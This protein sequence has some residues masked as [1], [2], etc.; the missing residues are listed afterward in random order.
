MNLRIRGILALPGIVCSGSKLACTEYS[1]ANRVR[2]DVIPNY[3][4]P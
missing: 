3:A 2:W 4:L 1:G